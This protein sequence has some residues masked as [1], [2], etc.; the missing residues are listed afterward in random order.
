M[1]NT[2]GATIVRDDV[3]IVAHTLTIAHVIAFAFCIAPRL[4]NS[5]VGAFRQAGPARD[6]FISN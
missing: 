6:A 2:F 5:L 4:E 3:N 1:P